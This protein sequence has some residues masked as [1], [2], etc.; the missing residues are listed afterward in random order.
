ME[1]FEADDCLPDL[2]DPIAI[3][4]ANEGIPVVAIARLLHRPSEEV[5]ASL[6]RALM[7]G[8][9]AEVPKSDWPPTA[10][11]RDRLPV[12]IWQLSDEDILFSCR[13]AFSLTALEAGFLVVLIKHDRADKS[14]LHN[15]V[16]MRRFARSSQPAKIDCTDPKMVDVMICKLRKKLKAVDSTL[17]IDTIWGGGYYIKQDVKAKMFACIAEVKDG[18]P[19]HGR[20]GDPGNAGQQHEAFA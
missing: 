19:S 13:K 3:R 2:L 6:R 12:I 16:E 20:S 15:V 17:L 10:K 11:M 9:I 8:N 7:C 1:V 14:K 5:F 18:R 4:A